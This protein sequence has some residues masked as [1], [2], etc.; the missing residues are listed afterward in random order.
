MFPGGALGVDIFF[1]I[2][3][4]L[5]TSL[6]LK[7]ITQGSFSL[8]HFINRRLLK[9]V[10]PLI[11]VIVFTLVV[12]FYLLT[13][14]KLYEISQG[15]IASLSFVGNIYFYRETDYFGAVQEGTFPLLHLW[16]LGVEEQ[17]YVLLPA[18]LYF[19]RRKNLF[20][21]IL[22]LCSISFLSQLYLLNSQNSREAFFLMPFRFWEF[23]I[24]SLT[25][26]LASKKSNTLKQK[27]RF[28]TIIFVVIL[29][30]ILFFEP[31]TKYSN[32]FNLTIC[33][34]I[35]LLIFLQGEGTILKTLGNFGPLLTIGKASYS[36]YLWHLPPLYFLKNL[37][38]NGLATLTFNKSFPLMIASVGLGLLSY[39]FIELKATRA[40]NINSTLRFVVVPT[41]CLIII[42]FITF[43][44]NGFETH[45][46]K[47]RLSAQQSEIY[48]YIIASSP[49]G[50]IEIQEQECKFNIDSL[51]EE[52][53]KRISNCAKKFGKAI[54]ITG[55]SHSY[56]IYNL[57][58]KSLPEQPFI[59]GFLKGGCR[60]GELDLNSN[61][62]YEELKRFVLHHRS[63]VKILI[64]N[65][66]GSHFISDRF[67]ISDSNR[68]FIDKEEFKIDS[69][70]IKYT[71][72]YLESISFYTDVIW[73][74]PFIEPRI[75][76][77]NRRNFSRQSLT[78]SPTVIDRFLY[79][80]KQI[81]QS[82]KK[83]TP[84]NILN[85][86]QYVSL[87]EPFGLGT[88]DSI[89]VKKCVIYRDLDHLSPCGES[90]IAQQVKIP[91]ENLVYQK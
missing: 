42:S 54:V 31:G 82:I 75:D 22:F 25:C 62:Q 46:Y 37:E 15:A 9:L 35:S 89:L 50:A 69:K 76:L 33:L 5:V 83:N 51:N 73:L 81:E 2:S 70:E 38:S 79:L 6:I 66:S 17:F 10:P 59:V 86:L 48:N 45:Y 32:L 4:Y 18:I 44:T 1:V 28:E 21:I 47:S 34:S 61:C 74:G 19:F 30:T 72:D 14:S 87:V 23:G 52:V 53:E 11:L 63:D 27:T 80:D 40:E 29:L 3:G 64:Y 91:F 7:Q 24:G 26:I 39:K 84:S 68:A 58:T 65:Q 41:L 49:K 13:P 71:R 20:I 55:D 67:G 88:G 43:F 78:I 90:I 57:F 60:A 36:I 85:G 12:S 77:T 16:S 8:S 56:N